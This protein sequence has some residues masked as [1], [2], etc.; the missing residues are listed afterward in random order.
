MVTHE[1]PSTGRKVQCSGCRKWLQ[2]PPSDQVISAPCPS[3]AYAVVVQP[4]H[5]LFP[6]PKRGQADVLGGDRAALPVLPTR[7]LPSPLERVDDNI[8]EI[9][10]NDKSPFLLRNEA[11]EPKEE[12]SM[13][14]PFQA[15]NTTS[16]LPVRL[17]ETCYE[18]EKEKGSWGIIAFLCGIAVFSILGIVAFLFF[19]SSEP[20]HKMID[21]KLNE[22]GSAESTEVSEEP[23]FVS[24]R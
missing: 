22:E 13:S 10:E 17:D 15:K 4:E 8:G 21:M 18:G 9:G 12:V 24:N 3:C 16:D 23:D 5:C 20:S 2:C 19:Q 1:E 7:P 11:Q 14:E 6:L